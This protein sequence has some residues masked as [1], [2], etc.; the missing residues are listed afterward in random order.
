[1]TEV[2]DGGDDEVSRTCMS[3]CW[4]EE[5]QPPKTYRLESQ[6]QAQWPERFEGPG[7]EEGERRREKGREGERRGE[8]GREGERRGGK[9][10]EGEGR[11]E[12]SQK[13][14]RVRNS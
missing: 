12:K 9:G 7:E 2:H 6:A 14:L 8:K 13:Q 10:R 4:V 3:E 11:E 5:D 1:M